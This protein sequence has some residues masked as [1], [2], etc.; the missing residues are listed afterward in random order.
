[1]GETLGV[2]LED[3]L[4]EL[5]Q[6]QHWHAA[7]GARMFRVHEVAATRRVVDMVA[8]ISGEREPRP[9][10]QGTCMT[11]PAKP[12][13]GRGRRKPRMIGSRDKT[14]MWSRTGRHP[15]SPKRDWSVTHTWER[16]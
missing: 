5:S 16:P 10:S 7:D 15:G 8:A 6:R 13:S 2:D 1:M 11:K 12:K 14:S 3:R 9:N 4:E